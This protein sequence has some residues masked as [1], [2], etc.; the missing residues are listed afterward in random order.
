M[1][2]RR[3]IGEAQNFLVNFDQSESVHP[4]ARFLHEL[5][6][7]GLRDCFAELEYSAGNGPAALER[8]L[9]PANEKHT[10]VGNNDSADRDYRTFGIFP[11][12]CQTRT[13]TA[14]LLLDTDVI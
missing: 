4:D 2:L 1:I 8:R 3:L 14:A 10:R 9:G 5:A 13:S 7:N 11:V 12:F 6:L